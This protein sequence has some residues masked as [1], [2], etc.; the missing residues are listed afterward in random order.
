MSKVMLWSF[1]IFL[2]IV[3]FEIGTQKAKENSFTPKTVDE[4][5][6][7]V[8]KAANCGNDDQPVLVQDYA[9]RITVNRKVIYLG[10]FS[11]KEEA[12]KAYDSAATKYFGNFARR[13]FS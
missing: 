5:A 8:G 12:A 11:A 9:A 13:N 7:I 6:Q 3:A 10:Y 1:V 4:A 2:A